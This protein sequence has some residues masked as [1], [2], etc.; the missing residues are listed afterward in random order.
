MKD[1]G[2]EGRGIVDRIRAV[3]GTGADDTTLCVFWFF[4]NFRDSPVLYVS[5]HGEL[6]MGKEEWLGMRWQWWV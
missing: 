4:S 5:D 3:I 1:S 6:L 2:G